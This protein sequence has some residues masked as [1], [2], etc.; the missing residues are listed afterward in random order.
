MTGTRPAEIIRHL[1]PSDA[2]LLARYVRRDEEAFAALVRRHGPLVLG[3]CR[4]IASHAQDAEDAF[5]AVFLILATKAAAIRSPH[6]SGLPRHP[7]RDAARRRARE[8]QAVNVPEPFARPDAPDL[9]ENDAAIHDELAKLPDRSREALVL[10]ELRGVP[11]AEAAALLGIPE[12]TLSSRLAAGRKQLAARLARRG[13]TLPAAIAGAVAVAVPDSLIA[14]TCGLVADWRAGAMMP[15]AVLRLT[16]GGLTMRTRMVLGAL[17]LALTAA[18]VVYAAQR[19]DPPQPND[20][21]KAEQ[22]EAKAAPAPPAAEAK[23]GAFTT[24]PRLVK[25]VDLPITVR[26]SPV[27]SRDGTRLAFFGHRRREGDPQ[28]SEDIVLVRSALFPEKAGPGQSITLERRG[29]LV[30]FTPDGKQIITDLREDSL[31][32][33]RHRLDYWEGEPFRLVK[34]V[35]L[36]AEPTFGYALAS[37]GKPYRTIFRGPAAPG[38]S[39]M[40]EVREVSAE[41]GKTLRVLL[42]VE[43]VAGGWT[44]AANGKRLAVMD[45]QGGIEV[46]NVDTA[47]KEASPR[48]S[49]GK[50]PGEWQDTTMRMSSDSHDLL[51]ASSTEQRVFDNETGQFTSK[52]EGETRLRG[53][54]TPPEPFSAKNELVVLAGGE[55]VATFGSERSF[56]KVWEVRTGKLLKSWPNQPMVAWSPVAPILAVAESNGD[57][58]TRLGL[59]DFSAAMPE[60]K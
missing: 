33:G 29:A 30:G 16:R 50:R 51:I 14:K 2:E 32:S 38:A 4:R 43:G 55:S 19:N 27:W 13:V 24:K 1:K 5:Q 22:P 52:L 37:D 46:W 60:K 18:G 45:D 54:G 35:D 47:K 59:W 42:T 25:A 26:S 6:L 40:I 57:G 15:A 39:G 10:C 11:R 49:K 20:P 8:V 34:S 31:I 12:G 3:V 53:Y 9:A 36:D 48:E 56:L 23:A 44:L 21:P 7:H 17:T 58:G 28:R 41:T